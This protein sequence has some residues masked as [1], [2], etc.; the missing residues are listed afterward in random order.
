MGKTLESYA[1]KKEEC[2]AIFVRELSL[3]NEY[4]L[5]QEQLLSEFKV[6]APEHQVASSTLQGIAIAQT[7][8]ANN[9]CIL[10]VEQ[11][12]LNSYLQLVQDS[13]S[14]L[15]PDHLREMD[16]FMKDGD[17]YDEAVEIIEAVI[18]TFD[19]RS[20]GPTHAMYL[21]VRDVLQ[22]AAK[23]WDAQKLKARSSK[24]NV[25]IHLCIFRRALADYRDKSF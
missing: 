25:L 12:A 8:A 7:D 16:D 22:F 17:L 23:A 1:Q 24:M 21:T 20:P 14:K 10:A 4:L 3:I 13:K 9:V 11:H 19:V 6:G 5:E 2:C 18:E 15:S